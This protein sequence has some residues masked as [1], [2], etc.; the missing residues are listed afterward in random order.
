VTRVILPTA[1]GITFGVG[2]ALTYSQAARDN[3]S[4]LQDYVRAPTPENEA[5][6][7]AAGYSWQLLGSFLQGVEKAGIP[8]SAPTGPT[9]ST[10]ATAATAPT[11]AVPAAPGDPGATPAASAPANAQAGTAQAPGDPASH[12]PAIAETVKPGGSVAR[13]V[14]TWL[15]DL[16]GQNMQSIGR[17]VARR[18]IGNGADAVEIVLRVLGGIGYVAFA[19]FLILF[20]FFFFCTGYERVQIA[21]ANLI[22][23]WRKTRT[24]ELLRQMDEVIAGFIRGRLIIMACLMVMFTI[25]YWLIG[26]PAF[27]LVGPIVGIIGV[28]PYIGMV[29]IPVSIA[30]MWFNP[31][32]PEWQQTWWWILFAPIGLYMLVQTI[33]DYVLTPTIQGKTTQMDMPTILFAVLAGGI[34]AGFYGILLAIPAAACLKILL[35]ESFWPRFRAWAEGRVKDFLPVSRYDPTETASTTPPPNAT[36]P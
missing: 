20:F 11:S 9:G 13:S 7:K 19:L 24:L 32:G 1:A 17:F 25:G 3:V 18:L 34:I 33:D 14:S 36:T 23:K 28:F 4:V 35:R 15:T 12:P 2:Q 30:L 5:R 8:P 27:F 31:H 10:G 26:V 6:L 29:S 22:P 16:V 21:L